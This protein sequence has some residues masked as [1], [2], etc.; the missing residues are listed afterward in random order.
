MA[1]PVYATNLRAR[2]RCPVCLF[3]VTADD[4]TARWAAKVIDLGGGNRFAP[5]VLRPSGVPEITDESQA[6]ADPELA[7]LSAMA[8]GRDADTGKSV[9][10]ALAAQMASLGLDADRSRLYFD[11]VLFSLSEAARR[12]LQ[13][14]D[15]AKYEYQ[16]DFARRYVA[17][18]QA[19]GLAEGRAALSSLI[20]KQLTSRFGVLPEDV[21]AR[22]AAASLRELETI[23]ERL[24]SAKTLSEALDR[25]Q[26]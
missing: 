23:G 8:H 9:Q 15:P 14:M 10:I 5:L 21:R 1:W 6:R 17:Q 24:L 20:A 3:V 16:S 2:L 7:V 25:I 4:A 22:I 19:E 26:D 13:S 18:G 12:E 11:L